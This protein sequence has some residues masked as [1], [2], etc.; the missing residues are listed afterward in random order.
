MTDEFV[1]YADEND[2]LLI[3]APLKKAVALAVMDEVGNCCVG[4]DSSKL[5]SSGEEK[6]ALAH[7][8]GHCAKGAFYNPYSPF[9]LRSRHEYRADCWA[10]EFLVPKE[11][12][13]YALS[14]GNTEM[15]QL[16]E[17]FDLPQF[18]MEKIVE[19]YRIKS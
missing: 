5:S 14:E 19:H 16:A 11:R 2:I 6:V 13:D 12:L 10:F 4:I 17:Y 1:R 18:Y 15:W 3:D 9:D 8:L 7:E